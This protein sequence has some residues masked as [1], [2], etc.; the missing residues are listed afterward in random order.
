MPKTKVKSHKRKGTKGVKK[1]SRTTPKKKIVPHEP[2]TW[3]GVMYRP[4]L[5]KIKEKM[6]KQEKLIAKVR[7][8]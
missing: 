5:D 3:M 7:N 4:E 2:E 8:R 6:R 1:H